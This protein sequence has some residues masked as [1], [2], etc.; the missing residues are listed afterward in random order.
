MGGYGSRGPNNLP[1]PSKGRAKG[2][3][4]RNLNILDR[5]AILSR[6]SELGADK[7][8]EE[9]LLH[10][11]KERSAAI[12]EWYYNQK[13]GAPKATIVQEIADAEVLR[14]CSKITAKFIE[15]S[16]FQEW[17]SQVKTELGGLGGES[18]QSDSTE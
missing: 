10:H 3:K 4:N 2:S 7:L 18:A 5:Y 12:T 16:D 11:L 13:M 1:G 6:F 14:V 8:A 9:S 15:P 17:L